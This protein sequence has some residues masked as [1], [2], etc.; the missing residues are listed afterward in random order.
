MQSAGFCE[1]VGQR[2]EELKKPHADEPFDP[3][4]R[5]LYYDPERGPVPFIKRGRGPG[6]PV[7]YKVFDESEPASAAPASA[8]W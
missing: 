1:L 4:L 6:E 8:E 7:P 2:V 3:E 5:K